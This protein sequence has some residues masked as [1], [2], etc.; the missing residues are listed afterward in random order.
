[1]IVSKGS[2]CRGYGPFLN[3]SNLRIHDDD[4]VCALRVYS[5]TKE[6]NGLR[7]WHHRQMTECKHVA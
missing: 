4:L 5:Y 3:Y 6:F 2:A 7:H 1:M